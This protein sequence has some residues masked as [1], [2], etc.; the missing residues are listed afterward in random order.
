MWWKFR[1]GWFRRQFH[2]QRSFGL[3]K[4]IDIFFQYYLN[5]FMKLFYDYFNPLRAD[6]PPPPP[7]PPPNITIYLHFHHF[8]L[9]WHLH[10]KSNPSS[11][12]TNSR[13][14]LLVKSMAA[15]NVV[16][17]IKETTM[18][19]RTITLACLVI[20]LSTRIPHGWGESRILRYWYGGIEYGLFSTG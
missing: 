9:K 4:L 5:I 8:L 12:T 6:P 10:C 1:V 11:W 20:L 19:S 16:K 17:E 7:P 15:T 18:V 14:C 13:F 3:S 2:V